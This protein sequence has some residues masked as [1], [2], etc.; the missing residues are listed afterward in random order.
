LLDSAGRL[1][2]IN[3]A[4][5]SETGTYSGIGF[6]VPVDVVNRIVPQLL[7]SGRVPRAGLGVQLAPAALG[8]ALGHEGA[9][10]LG[11][12]EGRPAE[13]AGLVPYRRREDGTY[14]FGDRIVALD[15]QTI[16]G[17]ED[18]QRRLAERSVGDE[19]LLGVVRGGR[20]REVRVRL[21]PLE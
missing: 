10:I 18:L 1:I 12:V 5:A 20:E 15:G 16:S 21:E 8:R 13:R 9:L 17:T 11:L 2:G 6:A 4:I 3:T 19:V 14:V 7:R